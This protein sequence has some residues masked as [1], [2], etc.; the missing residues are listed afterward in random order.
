M[1]RHPF[2][3]S[4]APE[5]DSQE[6]AAFARTEEGRMSPASSAEPSRRHFLIAAGLVGAGLLSGGDT[7]AA[8]ERVPLAPP[9]KQPPE[10]KVPEPVTRKAGWAVVGLGKLALEEVM[11]AFGLC[12]L[13]RPTAL[14]SGHPDKAKQV[15]KVSGI[16][17]RHLCDYDNY[18]R[19]ADDPDVDV[20]YIILPNSMHAEYTVRRVSPSRCAS[21]TTCWPIVTAA[22]P[23]RRA[24]VI[25]SI[26]P[27]A[28]STWTRPSAT[29]A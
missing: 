25:A 1:R 7:P 20:V 17:S 23:A 19:L 3:C 24:A 5:F 2:C 6:V 27:A 28:T 10:L 9:D 26:A 16:D 4:I 14:V 11:P 13:S 12:K 8:D 18:D 29:A 21:P 22:S 15:A